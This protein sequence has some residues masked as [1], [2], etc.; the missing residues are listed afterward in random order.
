[1]KH[2][3]KNISSVDISNAIDLWVHDERDRKILKRV[4]LDGIHYEALAEELDISVS[5]VRRAMDKHEETVFIK[6]ELNAK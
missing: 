4:L 5:T 6:A 3:Y 2:D 1:M